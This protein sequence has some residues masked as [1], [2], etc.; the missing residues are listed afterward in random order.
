MKGGKEIFRDWFVKA[1]KWSATYHLLL[2][3]KDEDIYSTSSSSSSS[4]STSISSDESDEDSSNSKE[5]K[6]SSENS[7]DENSSKSTTSSSISEDIPNV[8]SIKYLS[9]STLMTLHT[10]FSISDGYGI[11]FQYFFDLCQRC[12]EEKGEL[13]LNE[14]KYDDKIPV[15]VISDF[16][17]DFINGYIN[18][19]ESL[20]FD[21]DI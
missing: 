8:E 1:L 5:D 11:S 6:N 9:E 21:R 17:F 10:L 18:L 14:E 19:M 7:S 13:N 4:T 16:S 2:E 12:G 20:G 3:K 15:S